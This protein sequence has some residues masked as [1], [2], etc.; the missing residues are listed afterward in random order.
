MSSVHDKFSED[1]RFIVV[2]P[3]YNKDKPIKIVYENDYKIEPTDNPMEY[4]L[5]WKTQ[6]NTNMTTKE[7]IKQMLDD[8]WEQVEKIE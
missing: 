8:G 6:L 3:A 1:E 5:T 4:M 2:V 7:L